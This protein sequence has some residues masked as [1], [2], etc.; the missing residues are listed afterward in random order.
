MKLMLEML[1]NVRYFEWK[2]LILKQLFLVVRECPM[3][4]NSNGIC[5]TTTGQCTC[6]E[7]YSGDGCQCKIHLNEYS[8]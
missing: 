8:F 3:N 1:V 5:D 2:Y 7:N 4:C 6:N